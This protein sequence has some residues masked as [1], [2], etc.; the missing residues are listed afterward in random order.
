MKTRQ[1]WLGFFLANSGLMLAGAL[2]LGEPA[3]DL[4]LRDCQGA[5][6]QLTAYLH[7]KNVAVLAH[8][9]GA[10]P[11]MAIL[12]E[13]CRKLDALSTAVL[14][15]ETAGEANRKFLDNSS[16]ATVLIDSNGAV[17]RILPGETLTGADLARFA[18]LWLT[19]Q[20]VFTTRCARCHG[21]DGANNICW[22]VK[23]LAGIGKRLSE[24]QIRARLRAAEINERDVVI[25]GE[26]YSRADID[27]VIVYVAGL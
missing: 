4:A 24:A 25:R 3:P 12:D 14:F 21:E 22:D 9:P 10:K 18:Q 16:A 20:S 1:L 27:A 17:R 15:L 13:T 5:E 7:K 2:R 26:F 11:A 19:G 23:P 8:V 6:V